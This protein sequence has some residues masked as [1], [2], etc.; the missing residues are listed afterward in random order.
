MI[1]LS[2]LIVGVFLVAMIYCAQRTQQSNHYIG[3]RVVCYDQGHHYQSTEYFVVNEHIDPQDDEFRAA[4]VGSNQTGAANLKNIEIGHIDKLYRTHRH[5]LI[6][7]GHGR[8]VFTGPRKVSIQMRLKRKTIA[9]NDSFIPDAKLHPAKFT[10]A[11]KPRQV[12]YAKV[13]SIGT[14]TD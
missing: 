13:I 10:G 4:Y 14:S 2:V 11:G 8:V 3:A 1:I 6:K 9:L 12:G 7:T 5:Y